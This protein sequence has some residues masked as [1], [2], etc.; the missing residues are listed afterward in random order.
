MPVITV[1]YWAVLVAAI[2]NIV[3]GSLW[4]GPLFGKTWKRLM[5]FSDE[6]MKAMKMT[7]TGAYIGGIVTALLMA[8]VLAHSVVLWMAFPGTSAGTFSFALELA[9]WIWLGY[10]ATTQAGSVLWEG[11][12]LKLFFLN[13]A[14][15][16]VSLI[17]MASIL[18]F[19][20]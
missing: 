18:V 4:Y 17:V 20:K 8:F 15:S 1:N 14:Q 5:G 12:S 6:S 13:T 16:L 10:V 19:W 3:I 9:F 7:V 2:A 11:K